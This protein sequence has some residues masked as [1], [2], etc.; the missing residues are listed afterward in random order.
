MILFAGGIVGS[1][2]ASWRFCF[3]VCGR[4][5]GEVKKGHEVNQDGEVSKR[6]KKLPTI[7]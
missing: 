6:V 4:W 3:W 5:S 1:N 2:P 7:R